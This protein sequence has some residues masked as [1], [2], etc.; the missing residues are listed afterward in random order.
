MLLILQKINQFKVFHIFQLFQLH[1]K[2]APYKVCISV[3]SDCPNDRK[4][5]K[6][7]AIHL[8][9]ELKK[10]RVPVYPCYDSGKNSAQDFN[11]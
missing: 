7:I 1:T 2:L 5:L 4:R 3:N 6:D 11:R 8:E 10:C 9:K